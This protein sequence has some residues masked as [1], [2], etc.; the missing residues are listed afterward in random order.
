LQWNF[1]MKLKK[2]FHQLRDLSAMADQRVLL[3]W[4]IEYDS[5]NEKL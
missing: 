5:S 3:V 4:V 2:R 1:K